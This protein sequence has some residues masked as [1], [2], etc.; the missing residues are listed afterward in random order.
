MFRHEFIIE[1]HDI[2]YF[3]SRGCNC[4]ICCP[5]DVQQPHM[6]EFVVTFG[7]NR[8]LNQKSQQILREYQEQMQKIS[9]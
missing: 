7:S 4:L 2:E 3:M 6:Q 8:R 5:V 1:M 9:L